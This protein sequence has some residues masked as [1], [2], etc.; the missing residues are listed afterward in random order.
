MVTRGSLVLILDRRLGLKSLV[1]FSLRMSITFTMVCP[2]FRCKLVLKKGTGRSGTTP[3]RNSSFTYPFRLRLPLHIPTKDY[4]NSLPM[5]NSLEKTRTYI[6]LILGTA[7]L[8]SLSAN[9]HVAC[10]QSTHTIRYTDPL[11]GPQQ[12]SSS[13]TA[14]T[15]LTTSSSP[16]LTT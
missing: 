6:Q 5:E 1:L 14:A 12:A 16:S 15:L 4:I 9:S 13:Y 2:G 11:L 7:S 8:T 10:F 3:S